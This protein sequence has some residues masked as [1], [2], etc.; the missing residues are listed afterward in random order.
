MTPEMLQV[1]LALVAEFTV[2]LGVIHMIYI[3]PMKEKFQNIYEKM[4]DNG[5]NIVAVKTEVSNLT[6]KIKENGSD[7]KK[8][9]DAVARLEERSKR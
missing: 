9:I 5:K 6:S 1:I 4:E 7:T 3:R 8:L 2:L